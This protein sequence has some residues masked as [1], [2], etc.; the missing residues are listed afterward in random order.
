MG[1]VGGQAAPE[2]GTGCGLWAAGA[3]AAGDI[4]GIRGAWARKGSVGARVPLSRPPILSDSP[5]A[6][7]SLGRLP[8]P[9]GATAAGGP[10]APPDTAGGLAGPSAAGIGCRL[11]ARRASALPCAV[12]TRHRCS[13]PSHR[14]TDAMQPLSSGD[15]ISP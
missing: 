1:T 11:P 7:S 4:S 15:C 14:T 9:P 5:S 3:I 10:A 13:L 12:L 6:P 2:D 8:P